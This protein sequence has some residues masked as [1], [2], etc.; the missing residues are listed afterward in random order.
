[1]KTEHFDIC[2][3]DGHEIRE[4]RRDVTAGELRRLNKKAF[5]HTDGNWGWT[6]LPDDRALEGMG[7]GH[8]IKGGSR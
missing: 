5:C 2:L 3:T 1:M 6:R 4:V 8:L 7:H